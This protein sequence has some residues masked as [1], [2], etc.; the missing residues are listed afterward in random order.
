MPPLLSISPEILSG[1]REI[2][3]SV[4]EMTNNAE[5]YSAE[6]PS[7][8]GFSNQAQM[9]SNPSAQE[10]APPRESKRKKTLGY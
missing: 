2:F 3:R 9:R 7:F 1:L 8:T 6:N 10:Q 4:V 5:R